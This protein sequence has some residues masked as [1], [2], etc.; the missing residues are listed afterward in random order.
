MAL[1]PSSLPCVNQRTESARLDGEASPSRM[2]TRS[3]PPGKMI[4]NTGSSVTVKGKPGKTP[5]T[6]SLGAAEGAALLPCGLQTWPTRTLFGLIDPLAER[7]DQA[8][9]PMRHTERDGIT[10]VGIV[11][12]ASGGRRRRPAANISISGG[13]PPPFPDTRYAPTRW[14]SVGQMQ[15]WLSQRPLISALSGNGVWCK[16]RGRVNMRMG[17]CRINVRRHRVRRTRQRSD[18]PRGPH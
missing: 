1:Y 17:K 9:K 18:Q 10:A 4:R 7:P 8:A 15:L 14:R 16:R 6:C 13:R 2:P 3:S 12:P 11:V 5:A